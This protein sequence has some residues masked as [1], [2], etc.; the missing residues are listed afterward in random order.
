MTYAQVAVYGFSEK[1]GLLSFPQRE[2]SF[3]MTKPYSSKT[4]AIIDT[5]VREW[6]AKAYEKT[7]QVI[8]EHKEQVA[9]IAELLLEKEVLHQEDLIKVL[10]ERPFKYAELSNY[11][12]FKQGFQ[13]EDDKSVETPSD[14]VPVE[15]DGGAS[16]LIPQVVPT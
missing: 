15:E 14:T 16:P 8:E 10:G 13:E 6:V 3:E 4:G 11:E 12:K 5:E 9:Q 1:V 2:D 7:V